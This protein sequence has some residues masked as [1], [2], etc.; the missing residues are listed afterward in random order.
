MF[1]I[2]LASFFAGL[3]SYVLRKGDIVNLF[4]SIYNHSDVEYRSLILTSLGVILNIIAITLWQL[5][6]RI[7][8]S[9]NSAFSAY[10]SL[11][12]VFGYIVSSLFEKTEYNINF[13]I[14]SFLILLG[15]KIFNN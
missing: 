8:L 1:L 7:N 5:S 9:F 2:I 3:G 15:I 12:L 6:S 13:F 14:G 11:T 10:L 4:L